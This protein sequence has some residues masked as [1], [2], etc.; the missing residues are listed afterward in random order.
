MPQ[1]TPIYTDYFS[2]ISFNYYHAI[3]VVKFAKIFVISGNLYNI[4]EGKLLL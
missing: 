2:Q 1:I 3:S 4:I